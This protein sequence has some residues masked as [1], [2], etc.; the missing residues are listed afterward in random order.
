[1]NHQKIYDNII[2][3][4]KAENRIKLRKDNVD[5]VYYENHHVIPKCLEG[6]DKEHN[7]VLLTAR[8][9][10]V[11][12]KLLTYIYKGNRK[13]TCAFHRMTYNKKGKLILTSRDYLYARELMSK[14]PIT[15]ER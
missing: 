4:A 9:H 14:T 12:H 8:E 11:C 2:E 15:Q 1:M 6:S 3:K 10:F 5:Y 7:K 13:I